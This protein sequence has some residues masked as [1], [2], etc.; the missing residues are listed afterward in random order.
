M[1]AQQ[2]T[3]VHII[4]AFAAP[5]P[6]DIN[7]NVGYLAIQSVNG[8]PMSH[9]CGFIYL[10]NYKESVFL[11]KEK[12]W[13]WPDSSSIYREWSAPLKQA[14]SIY[15]KLFDNNYSDDVKEHMRIL[16]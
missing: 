4:C 3:N 12:Y 9:R 11:N 13:P 6:I 15:I 7:P 10:L 16:I 5:W 8:R 2:Q 1:H 14:Y